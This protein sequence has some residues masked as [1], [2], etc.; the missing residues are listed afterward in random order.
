MAPRG[1]LDGLR[2]LHPDVLQVFTEG[3]VAAFPRPAGVLDVLPV[4]FVVR[5]ATDDA[6]S[7][8]LPAAPSPNEYGGVA[9]FAFRVPLQATSSADV[10]S[11]AF[12]VLA[13]EDP[14]TRVTESI[15]EGRDTAA[16]RLLHARA[17]SLGATTVTVLAGSP[18]GGPGVA[19]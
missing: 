19:A 2:A 16:V 14:E 13:V 7:R 5:R 8:A 18:A 17:A 10:Y 12:Q 9:T 11:L 15:E 1:D 6:T 4:G 3:E